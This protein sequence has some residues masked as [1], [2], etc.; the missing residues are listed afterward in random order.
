M[1]GKIKMALNS[2]IFVSMFSQLIGQEITVELK[3]DLT[4]RGIL[5]GVDQYLNLKL[6]NTS[7]LDTSRYPH[8]EYVKSCFVRGSVVRYIH[9]DPKTVDLAKMEDATRRATR[10]SA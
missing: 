5:Q 8:M 7:T 3:N 1:K 4:I 6:T 10:I 9:L 2:P